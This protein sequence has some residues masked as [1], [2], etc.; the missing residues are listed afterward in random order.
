MAVDKA[1]AKKLYDTWR[2]Q[3]DPQGLLSL[4]RHYSPEFVLQRFCSGRARSTVVFESR[5]WNTDR[6]DELLTIYNVEE[7]NTEETRWSE[8]F[9]AVDIYWKII[10]NFSKEAYARDRG[11]KVFD[12]LQSVDEQIFRGGLVDPLWQIYQEEQNSGNG[13]I[14]LSR[15]TINTL[16]KFLFLT[17][18]VQN[19]D[20]NQHLVLNDD[21]MTE[22]KLKRKT[23]MTEKRLGHERELWLNNTSQIL[24]THHYDVA[25]N[26]EVSELDRD[27]YR[28]NAR[29]RFVVFWK[30]AEKG[31]EFILTDN[32]F[33]CFEGGSLGADAKLNINMDK[34]EQ[35]RHVYTKDYM[36]HS[37]YVISP[38]LVIAL[39]HGSL[40]D[41]ELIRQHQKRYGLGPSLLGG[42]PH[43]YPK[44][45]Y[46][47]MTRDECRF[48]DNNWILPPG[49]ANGFSARVYDGN[50]ATAAGVEKE[51]LHFPIQTLQPEQVAKVNA[52]LL[53]SR[54]TPSPLESICV[55]P[56]AEQCLLRALAV[57]EKTDWKKYSTVSQKR[58]YST[59]RKQ[60][61]LRNIHRRDTETTNSATSFSSAQSRSS[62]SGVPITPPEENPFDRRSDPPSSPQTE[63]VRPIVRP[64]L[65]TRDPIPDQR[66]DPLVPSDPNVGPKEQAPPR[67][68]VY[69]DHRRTAAP[70]QL[71]PELEQPR[72]GRP[73]SYHEGFPTAI[74]DMPPPSAEQSRSRGSSYFR[75]QKRMAA[76]GQHDSSKEQSR[77]RGSSFY[78]VEVP[79]T[80]ATHP[81]TS[82]PLEQSWHTVSSSSS[83]PDKH[84]TPNTVRAEPPTPRPRTRKTPSYRD[85]DTVNIDQTEPSKEQPRPRPTSIYH[86]TPAPVEQPDQNKNHSSKKPPPYHEKQTTINP[87]KTEP[88]QERPKAPRRL[89]S[90]R[91]K[92]PTII[93]EQPEPSHEQLQRRGSTKRDKNTEIITEQ[94]PSPGEQRYRR[95]STYHDGRKTIIKE[96]PQST[97]KQSRRMS[98]HRDIPKEIISEQPEASQEHPRHPKKL[99]PSDKPAKIVADDPEAKR[100]QLRSQRS[101]YYEKHSKVFDDSEATLET[102]AR[103]R[104]QRRTS[105]REA[106]R[107]PT[108]ETDDTVLVGPF[109]SVNDDRNNRVA[110]AAEY[111]QTQQAF[112]EQLAFQPIPASAE[113]VG[114]IRNTG[115]AQVPII[116]DQK[117]TPT[118]AN[119]AMAMPN[120][121]LDSPPRKERR[122]HTKPAPLEPLTPLETLT[123]LEGLDPFASSVI[124]ELG[125]WEDDGSF[126]DLEDK[127][128]DR[129]P[130]WQ[131]RKPT[132]RF[133]KT[134]PKSFRKDGVMRKTSF[135]DIGRVRFMSRRQQH[136]S[137]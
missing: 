70:E 69:R 95:T 94:P 108:I 105:Y 130:T 17:S 64:H 71:V 113:G 36:W 11:T 102:P 16:R 123:P 137:T 86:T 96:Q 110:R 40:A 60:L 88:R 44:N 65:G 24:L 22:A 67:R 104:P 77:S 8:S 49:F 73:M 91:N 50:S 26:P 132:V 85:S 90:L 19:K 54:S 103:T 111:V 62:G 97:R 133:E 58:G 82:T 98:T 89:S 32:S 52:V 5:P 30:P 125:A 61:K 101:G 21:R 20:D 51:T 124:V 9:G 66:P 18:S 1:W 106:R 121:T 81:S 112:Q 33:G 7:K 116:G 43:I 10:E 12:T 135:A 78:C 15:H 34:S 46:K 47:D 122:Y 87:E 39:C 28:A 109:L 128:E 134:S 115:S 38:T 59:L 27:D 126:E 37:L 41:R 107:P 48:L 136:R 14:T 93:T 25:S 68:T 56:S 13:T 45:Y 100:E 131:P 35:A 57:F 129:S 23:F 99:A 83:Y 6:E 80:L 119:A 114:G 31:D 75:E 72:I 92:H 53:Q 118:M 42:L 63:R 117:P 120:G 84:T 29:E 76:S 2:K 79:Q 55:R 74:T 127:Y 3:Q 4:T